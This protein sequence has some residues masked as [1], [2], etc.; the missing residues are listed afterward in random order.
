MCMFCEDYPPEVFTQLTVEEYIP[1][2]RGRKGYWDSRNRRNEMI[3]CNVYNMAMWYY[4]GAHGWTKED[5]DH[6]ENMLADLAKGVSGKKI[7]A[8]RYLGRQTFK[9]ESGDLI[10]SLSQTPTSY[11]LLTFLSRIMPLQATCR[12]W[13]MPSSGSISSPLR[14]AMVC[15]SS[16]P[17]HRIASP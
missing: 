5:Y 4:S 15:L 16:I 12:A 13:L 9:P 10:T 2:N 17:V 8:K 6:R 14:I 7:A 3:D 1:G 11:L